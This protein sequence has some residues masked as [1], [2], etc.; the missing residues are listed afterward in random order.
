MNCLDKMYKEIEEILKKE[1]QE[2]LAELRPIKEIKRGFSSS[3]DSI[4]EVTVTTVSRNY[5]LEIS[6]EGKDWNK[7]Y[8]DE[9]KAKN[10]IKFIFK[11][12]LCFYD[13]GVDVAESE[14]FLNALD[15]KIVGNDLLS[16]LT[17]LEN[18]FILVSGVD[19]GEE[20]EKYFLNPYNALFKDDKGYYA[21][22]D[23]N[24]F[25]DVRRPVGFN[26][27]QMRKVVKETIDVIAED[28]RS[29]FSNEKE[30][31]SFMNGFKAEINKA[32]FSDPIL[33]MTEFEEKFF[34]FL[35]KKGVSKPSFDG[36]LNQKGL[37]IIKQGNF[38][39]RKKEYEN[40][41]K[42]KKIEFRY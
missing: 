1:E 35:E 38:Y 18:E 41:A 3:F 28:Y 13:D 24:K 39:F 26:F 11:K 12:Y 7:K 10:F 9:A 36:Y 42:Y 30:L 2:R 25:S 34:A 14:A 17:S 8:F 37:R 23:G 15:S 4:D 6:L 27:N 40:F 20:T 19:K 31:I 22:I 21:V 5:L 29:K 33:I 16:V 32:D